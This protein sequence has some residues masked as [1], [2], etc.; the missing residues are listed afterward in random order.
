MFGGRWLAII[1]A[2][3][4]A[5]CR[6]AEAPESHETAVAA[7]GSGLEANAPGSDV[8][9]TAPIG[10]VLTV[11]RPVVPLI[12]D[13]RAN[14]TLKNNSASPVQI[15]TEFLTSGSLTLEVRDARGAR[16]ALCACCCAGYVPRSSSR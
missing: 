2:I 7:A 12:R 11:E 5:G 1:W 10:A 4:I 16:G 9:P 3:G 15:R 6:H 13:V 14:V 8:P